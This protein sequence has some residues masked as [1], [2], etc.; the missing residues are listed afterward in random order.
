ME[1]D[2]IEIRL[3]PKEVADLL[4]HALG[5]TDRIPP[6]AYEV[7][8]NQPEGD[9]I[10]SF[11]RRGDAPIDVTTKALFAEALKDR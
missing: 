11:K 5:E 4:M 1:D 10:V 9:I 6:G 8:V 3:S 7:S 2:T